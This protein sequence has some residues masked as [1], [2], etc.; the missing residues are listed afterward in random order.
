[1]TFLPLTDRLQESFS[2]REYSIT[3]QIQHEQAVAIA[4]GVDAFHAVDFEARSGIA[5]GIEFHELDALVGNG[6]QE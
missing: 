1:M 4:V 2:C 6:C 5:L 3:F